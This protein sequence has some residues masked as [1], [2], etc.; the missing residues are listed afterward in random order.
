VRRAAARS[1]EIG[2]P[3]G[4]VRIFQVIVNKVEPEQSILARNLFAKNNVRSA[5]SDEMVPGWPQVPLVSKPAAFACRAE[6]LAWARA[7]PALT[8]ETGEFERIGPHADAGEEVTSSIADKV[9]RFHILYAAFV[10]IARGDNPTRDQVSQ[11]LRGVRIELVVVIHLHVITTSQ[12]KIM[13][14]IFNF[15]CASAMIAASVDPLNA[16]KRMNF[17]L[18]FC[19]LKMRELNCSIVLP[20]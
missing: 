6:R 17:G 9:I 11:P 1:T 3:H 5:L 2:R 15:D 18:G 19:M 7:G 10:D 20:T 12:P 16:A 14:D 4:V 8:L 13:S